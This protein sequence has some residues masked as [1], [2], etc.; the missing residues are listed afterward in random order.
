MWQVFFECDKYCFKQESLV[1]S[2]ENMTVIGYYYL[3][4]SMLRN[5]DPLNQNHLQYTRLSF[6]KE[7]LRSRLN[8]VSS[9]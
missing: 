6:T 9:K 4:V 1:E 7:I 2:L 8:K 3:L 5:Q